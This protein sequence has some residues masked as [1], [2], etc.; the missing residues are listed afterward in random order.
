MK[1]AR[2][3]RRSDILRVT[4]Q[5]TLV[6]LTVLVALPILG[7]TAFFLRFVVAAVLAIGL[8]TTLV[9]MLFSPRVR[10]WVVE[11]PDREIEYKGFRLSNRVGLATGHCWARRD[12]DGAFVGLD[13]LA[14]ACLGPV[15]TVEAPLP[16]ETFRA[17]EPLFA[18]RHGARKLV[19]PSPITGRVVATNEALRTEPERVRHDPYG[20]GW[21]ARIRP[22]KGRGSVRVLRGEDARRWFRRQ[23]DRVITATGGAPDAVPSMPDGGQV[24]PDL[25]RAIDDD[26]WERLLRGV[27]SAPIEEAREE[28]SRS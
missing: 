2:S 1:H 21:I 23:V 16:G 25:H 3:E 9:L 15:D 27:L 7:V 14:T 19:A 4:V 20:L 6:A 10:R 5:T 26:A 8:C 17:G 12:P 13:D 28:G 22:E 11:E 24:I 18:V